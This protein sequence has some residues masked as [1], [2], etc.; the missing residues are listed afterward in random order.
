V[1]TIIGF[2]QPAKYQL[3]PAYFFLIFWAASCIF[4]PPLSDFL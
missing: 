4:A 1:N 2:E 3:V